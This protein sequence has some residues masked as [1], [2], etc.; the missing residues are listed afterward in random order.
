MRPPENSLGV[1]SI[2]PDI[3]A[4]LQSKVRSAAT[5]GVSGDSSPVIAE[6]WLKAKRLE[7]IGHRADGLAAVADGV[8]FLFR[9]FGQGAAGTGVRREDGSG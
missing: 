2:M 6:L 4:T 9:N 5:E 7:P 1:A 8:L 3:G